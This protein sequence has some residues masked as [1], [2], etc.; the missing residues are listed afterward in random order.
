MALTLLAPA[1]VNLTLEALGRRGDGYHE[2]VSLVQTIEL[3]DRVRIEPSDSLELAITGEAV[4]GVPL[5]GPR[6]LAFKAA[7]ALTEAAARPALTARIVLEKQIPAGL[8][9]G[10]G[11]SDAAAALR[12][13]DR[14]WGL[15][16]PHEAL[17]AAAAGVGSDVPFF[18]EGGAA[19]LSGRGERVEPLPDQAPRDLTL[20]LGDLETEDKTRR[21]Y[22]AL[23]PADFSDGRRG[24]VAAAAFRRGLPLAKTDL[25]NVFDRHLATV[26]PPLAAAIELCRDAGLAVHALGSGPGFFTPAPLAAVPGPLLHELRAAWGVRALACRSLGREA[27]LAIGES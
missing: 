11:S 23:T 12:G 2:I 5:E 20:F 22:A 17:L 21:M 7:Q 10:G 26:A 13:L 15:A 18:L 14:F 8:G 16:L 6:N 24:H 1:K 9:L 25:V 27:A 19:L 3:A 4:L